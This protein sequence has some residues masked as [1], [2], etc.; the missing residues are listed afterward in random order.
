MTTLE[1]NG[2]ADIAI[3]VELLPLPPIGDLGVAWADLEQRSECSFFTGWCWIGCWLD[4]L[5]G[6]AQLHLLRARQAERIVGMGILSLQGH[7]RNGVIFS[8][9]LHLHA[10]GSHEFDILAVECNSFLVERGLEELVS[11]RMLGHLIEQ[12]KNWDELA[13]DGLSGKP[14]WLVGDSRTG[15]RVNSHANHYIVLEAIRQNKGGYLPLLGAK[16]RSRIR[17]SVKEYE[18][19]GP[20]VAHAAKDRS[21]ALSFLEGL[22][23]LHQNYWVGRGEPGAFANAFFDRFHQKLVHDAFDTGEIQIIAVDAGDRRLGYIYN[24]VYRGRIYNYQSGFNYELCERHNRPGLVAHACAIEL[25]A[26]S[27]HEIYDFLAGDSE[28][29]QALGTA[30]GAMSWVV[31][32]RDR[33]R[34]RVEA[35]GRKLRDRLRRSGPVASGQGE[36]ASEVED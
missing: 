33:M 30:V 17:R 31:V 20:V 35:L 27:G 6:A 8:R 7:R 14:N 4:S 28:Y 10:T 13:L 24:F 18:Q 3:V 15:V 5:A 11:A 9:T 34:F 25:N 21:Q 19:F 32:Q 12:E 2:L 1:S 26:R 29:K 16:T 36:S 23:A 22:K